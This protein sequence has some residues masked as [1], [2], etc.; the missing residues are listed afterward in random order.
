MANDR[1]DTTMTRTKIP[2]EVQ[3]E[4]GT[5]AVKEYLGQEYPFYFETLDEAAEKLNDQELIKETAVYLQHRQK[6]LWTTERL[7]QELVASEI[8]TAPPRVT[9]T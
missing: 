2:D 3:I 8:Y 7:L 5:P 4:S 9:H 1:V 6:Y